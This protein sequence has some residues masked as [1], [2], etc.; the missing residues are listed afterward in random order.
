MNSEPMNYFDVLVA[1]YIYRKR[2]NTELLREFLNSGRPLTPSIL[3]L[4]GEALAFRLSKG[5]GRDPEPW[6]GN[7]PFCRAILAAYEE[8]LARAPAPQG[9]ARPRYRQHWA[10]DDVR[11]KHEPLRRLNLTRSS[12]LRAVAVA[13]KNSA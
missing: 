1:I 9:R 8:A 12:V 7:M 13:R 10:A 6:T 4:M 11:L 3:H 2:G 5:A